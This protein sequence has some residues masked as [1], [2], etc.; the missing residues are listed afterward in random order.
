[1]GAVLAVL[2]GIHAGRCLFLQDIFGLGLF[3]EPVPDAFD[4]VGKGPGIHVAAVLEDRIVDGCLLVFHDPHHLFKDRRTARAVPHAAAGDDSAVL[5]PQGRRFIHAR[6]GL[7]VT[8]ADGDPEVLVLEFFH[9]LRI[10]LAGDKVLAGKEFRIGVADGDVGHAALGLARPVDAVLV[11]AVLIGYIHDEV[12]H[13]GQALGPLVGIGSHHADRADEVFRILRC[14]DDGRML[15]LFFRRRPD[16]GPVALI[17]DGLGVV[18][19][20]AGIGDEDDHGIGLGLVG[21]VIFG[22]VNIIRH[23]IACSRVL[24]YISFKGVLDGIDGLVGSQGRRRRAISRAIRRIDRPG[25]ADSDAQVRCLAVGIHGR[26]AAVQGVGAFFALIAL[27]VLGL[28][29]GSCRRQGRSRMDQA[30]DDV[31]AL[32]A[33]QG[34]FRR[35]IGIDLVDCLAGDGEIRC[36]Q[37]AGINGLGIMKGHSR[38]AFAVT[39]DRTQGRHVADRRLSRCRRCRRRHGRLIQAIHCRC[40]PDRS[41][42]AEGTAEHSQS[43]NMFTFHEEV[44]SN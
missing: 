44:T 41:R 8:L 38:Y 3:K 18:D 28:V 32:L 34:R 19:V 43:G 12:R 31:T 23:F 22:Q 25:L 17:E 29:P 11:D 35:I 6:K 26:I 2:F 7:A 9:F 10:P 36:L 16:D 39:I 40:G 21:V 42:Q 14:Q 4:I 30:D 24:I 13:Q 33:S 1:M 15:G 37:A 27:V 5:F 20:G